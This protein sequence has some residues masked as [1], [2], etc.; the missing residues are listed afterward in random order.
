MRRWLIIAG[1]LSLV[2]LLCMLGSATQQA[3]VLA[4]LVGGGFAGLVVL[5][6]VAGLAILL[7]ASLTL[8][9]SVETETQTQLNAAVLLVPFLFALWVA[10]MIRGRQV[11]LLHNRAVYAALAFAAASVVAFLAGMQPLPF[12]H[13]APLR[14]Q[15]GGLGVFLLSVAAFVLVAHQVRTLSALRLLTWLFLAVGSL[16]VIG[17]TVPGLDA[18][19]HSLF[20]PGATGSLYWTWLVA[21]AFSQAAFNRSLPWIG[22]ALLA[23]LVVAALQVGLFQATWWASGWLPPLVAVL[24]SL[25]VGAPRLAFFVTLVGVAAAAFESQT[26]I[27]MVMVGDQEYSLLTRR[28]AFWVL[29]QIIGESPLLGLGPANYYYHTPNYS[30]LGWFV[31]FSSHNNYVDII[32]Q[33]GLLG[34]ATFCWLVVELALL[35][36]RLRQRVP[37]GF[38]QAYVY[39]VIGGLAGTLVAATMADWLVPFVYNVG[40]QGFRSSVLGWIFLGGLVSVAAGVDRKDA[41]S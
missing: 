9:V 29:A 38:T 15:L 23:G 24:V 5:R 39:G 32:A 12:V 16:Y 4:A 33:T 20:Q 25:W 8:D 22:R 27:Q 13:P 35:G 40:M 1:V 28:E 18:L 17:R 10:G 37:V 11:R 6:P 21:L 19:A 41:H 26:I 34:F 2:S 31:S 3:F 14:A 7:V 30:I 36:W